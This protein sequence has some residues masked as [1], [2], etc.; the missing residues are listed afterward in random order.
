MLKGFID[1]EAQMASE[2]INRALNAINDDI[3]AQTILV[4][5]WAYW[6]DTYEFA[7]NLNKDYIKSNL[8][9]LTFVELNIDFIIY[10]DTMGKILLGKAVD[11]ETG[12]E[13]ELPQSLLSFINPESLYLTKLS[14]SRKGAKTQSL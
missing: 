3:N 6:D 12:K 1:H 11:N 4:I 8:P 14:I 7:N 9:I 13:I 2:N 10:L 5:D